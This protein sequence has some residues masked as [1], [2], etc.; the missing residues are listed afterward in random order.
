MRPT[1]LFYGTN[2]IDKAMKSCLLKRYLRREKDYFENYKKTYLSDESKLISQQ[3]T[4]E[5]QQLF[6]WVHLSCVNWALLVKNKEPI[7]T[8][9][10][11]D[12]DDDET[13][14]E[15]AEDTDFTQSQQM[16]ALPEI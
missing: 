8:P 10:A 12:Q 5:Y 15:D 3:Q 13:L 14:S 11:E 16:N 4:P 2:K 9:Q 1:T 7:P 6:W